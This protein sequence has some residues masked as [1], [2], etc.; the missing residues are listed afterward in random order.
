M[1]SSAEESKGLIMCDHLEQS[2][3]FFH[4]EHFKEHI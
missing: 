1:I 4:N 3:F 2:L